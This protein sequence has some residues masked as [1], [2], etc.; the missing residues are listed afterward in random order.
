MGFVG[1]IFPRHFRP[2][3]LFFTKMKNV[4][5]FSIMKINKPTN[6]T[7]LRYKLTSKIGP[8]VGSLDVKMAQNVHQVHLFL[9][10]PPSLKENRL[11]IFNYKNRRT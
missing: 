10:K 6:F 11:T 7:G 2:K 4:I 1:A 3:I 8:K 5:Q 9:I